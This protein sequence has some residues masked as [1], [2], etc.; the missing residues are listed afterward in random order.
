MS[1]HQLPSLRRSGGT[2]FLRDGVVLSRQ[3]LF[4][5]DQSKSSIESIFARQ[6]FDS[7]GRPAVEVE[8]QLSDGSLG[9][10]SVPSGAST[11]AFEAHELRDRNPDEYN[12]LGVTKAVAN[13]NGEIARHLKGRDGLAQAEIDRIL[14]DLDGTENLRRL[15]A[16]ACL[17]VSL[18][19]CRASAKYLD[20]PLLRRIAELSDT[21]N[22]SIPVPM[23]NILSGGLHARMG[24]DVQDFL[25]IPTRAQSFVEAVKQIAVVRSNADALAY[26]NGLPTLLADEGGLSPAFASGGEALSFMTE[27]IKR[28]NL[29]PGEDAA[30][31]I[32]MAASTLQAESRSY[33]FE[34]ENREYSASEIISLV[35]SWTNEFAVLSVE[36]ALGEEDSENWRQLN[37]QLGSKIQL[38]GDDL[39]ATNL[40]RLEKGIADC[41]ANTVLIKLNQNGTLTG[42]LDVIKKAKEHG[43]ATIVSARS[44]ETEDDFI[45]DLAVGTDAGQIKI[46]SFRNSERLSKYNRLL[47]I[48]E[49]TRARMS[50][51]SAVA[52]RNA[53]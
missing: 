41:A 3:V 43:F 30:I 31:A 23:V 14:L 42:T 11:G 40:K 44:G 15:G 52:G 37:A 27:V 18:A 48:A 22:I 34:R 25:F 49:W 10:A 36:D 39:F 32:D 16:N 9:R 5:V 2:R 13:V 26:E 6:I 33:R 51:F 50:Q 24:M 53:G 28:S 12:G 4:N 19:L 45:A 21:K 47:R 20:V 17:G 29:T 38:V 8:V 46:G 35:G 7:R 1:V